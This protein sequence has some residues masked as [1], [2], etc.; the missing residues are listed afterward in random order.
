M[1]SLDEEVMVSTI[2]GD[3]SVGP[4]I[5]VIKGEYFN[6][7]I[8]NVSRELVWLRWIEIRQRNL[9]FGLSL[10][11]L[12]VLELYEEYF[13]KGEH[14]LEELWEADTDAPVQLTV[15]VI[16]GC[17]R[18]QRFPDS[19][20]RVDVLKK[21]VII[22]GFNLTSL[23]EEFCHLQSLEHL[24]LRECFSAII[25]THQFWRL[26]KFAVSRFES[27]QQIEDVTSFV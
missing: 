16:S 14:H 4:K 20:G 12:S 10:K 3:W 18:F 19:I 13:T 21:I 17:K 5:F 15:L 2:G 9:P 6:R 1:V 7:A 25:T 11:K 26:E 22:Q 23:P 27:V 8:Y 24:E